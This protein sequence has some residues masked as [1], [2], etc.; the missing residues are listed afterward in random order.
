VN[1]FAEHLATVFSPVEDDSIDRSEILNFL[2][3]PCQLSLPVRFFSSKEV[4]QELL[5]TNSHKA[6]GFELVVGD[7]LK[8]LPKKSNCAPYNIMLRLC[9]YPIQW[10][11]AQVI[12]TAK[13]S[14]PPTEASSY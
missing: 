3:A 1:I 11:I 7:I 9:H 10:K 4:Y 13:P 2:H 14:K 12:M 8:D 6:P 5:K